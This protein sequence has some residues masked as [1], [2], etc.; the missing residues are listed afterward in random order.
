MNRIKQ[1]RWGDFFIDAVIYLSLIFLIIVTL[2][3]FLN[4]LAISFNDAID[5]SRGGIH[6]WPRKFTL[7][8]YQSLLGRQQMLQASI[9]SVGRTVLSTIFC[10]FSTAMVAYTISR[11]E[12]VLR[13]LISFIYVLTMYIDGGLVPTY[14]LMRSLGLT[15]SF[16]VY[17]LPGLVSAFN[18]IVIRTYITSLPDSLVESARIDGAG[19]FT[20]FL[21]VILPL[22]KPVLATIALFVAVDNW[23][24][25]FDT[26]LYNSASANLSTLQYEL[27]KVLQ[28]A[29]TMTGSLLQALSRAAAGSTNTVTPRA[30]RATMTVIV[31][32]P[33]VV[34]YPFLQ[35]YFVH[36]LTLGGVKE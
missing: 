11:R 36:G 34:V 9:V 4:T 27:M 5:S 30:I 32:V 35:K 18:L 23:N 26:F 10:T 25:W 12:Y 33:I 2:Y 28:T 24:S 19:E 14:F 13:R 31:S 6:L 1:I 8:N 3:P 16:W 7:Y 22:C 20:I 29:N 21:R 17:V 15:N